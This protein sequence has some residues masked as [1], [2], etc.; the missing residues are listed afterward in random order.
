ML[1]QD[2][3]LNGDGT[4]SAARPYGQRNRNQRRQSSAQAK[5]TAVRPEPPLPGHTHHAQQIRHAAAAALLVQSAHKNVQRRCT[6]TGHAAGLGRAA[7]WDLSATPDQPA[8]LA[9]GANV[10]GIRAHVRIDF[11]A[12]ILVEGPPTSRRSEDSP[13]SIDR[14][15]TQTR[16]RRAVSCLK[17][18]TRN[19]RIGL[20]AGVVQRR[21]K[22][23]GRR[24]RVHDLALQQA[25]DDGHVPW[26]S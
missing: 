19:L 15:H 24:R 17:E 7:S 14:P 22:G 2:L 13:G 20:D 12:A 4:A 5:T 26:S 9:N 11:V 25:F 1:T 10:P 23:D 3:D 18:E 6:A 16:W 21:G 8:G